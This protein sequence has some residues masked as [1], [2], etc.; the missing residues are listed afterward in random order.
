MKKLFIT[1]SVCAALFLVLSPIAHS[2]VANHMYIDA[3]AMVNSITVHDGCCEAPCDLDMTITTKPDP[4]GPDT[5]Q[6]Y[7]IEATALGDMLNTILLDSM[8]AG[9]Q[10]DLVLEIVFVPW[11]VNVKSATL[12]AVP[13]P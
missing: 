5:P 8:M 11:S 3:I 7:D 2:A 1:F 9:V 6:T 13:T 10:I 12:P 4:D